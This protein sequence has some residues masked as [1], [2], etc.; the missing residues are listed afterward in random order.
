MPRAQVAE[1]CGNRYVKHRVG[2]RDRREIKLLFSHLRAQKVERKSCNKCTKVFFILHAHSNKPRIHV[3]RNRAG[4]HRERFMIQQQ[5]KAITAEYLERSRSSVNTITYES[6]A[7]SP[8]QHHAWHAPP[9]TSA[10]QLPTHTASIKHQWTSGSPL[11]LQSKY[12]H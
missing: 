2:E 3:Q 4:A 6:T 11:V 1:T 12:A 10:E 8:E 7:G 9:H 5:N